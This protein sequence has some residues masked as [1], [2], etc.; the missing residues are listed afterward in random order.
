MIVDAAL[1]TIG[2]LLGL[3]AVALPAAGATLAIRRL[4]T[5]RPAW[6]IRARRSARRIRR[7]PT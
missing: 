6:R 5:T 3:A 2:V 4:R 1:T 7:A